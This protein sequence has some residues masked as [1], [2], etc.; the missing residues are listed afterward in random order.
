MD[1]SG[2]HSHD[3][4]GLVKRAPAGTAARRSPPQL[5]IFPPAFA[6]DSSGNVYIADWGNHRIRRIDSSGTITT[7]AGNRGFGLQ[8]GRRPGGRRTIE[9]PSGGGGRTE[10]VTSTSLI[11]RT[12]AFAGWIRREPSQTVSGKRRAGLQW[13]QRP[14]G[15][16]TVELSLWRGAGWRRQ[17]L[18]RRFGEPPD[19]PDQFLRDHHHHRRNRGGFSAGDGGPAGVAQ[20]R[21]PRGIAAD[22]GRQTFTLAIPENHRIR[23]VD[24]SGV[25]TTIAGNRGAGLWRRQWLGCRRTATHSRKGGAGWRRQCLHHRLHGNHRIRRV[26]PFGI[27]TTIAG[28]GEQG[29]SGDNGLAV[30]AQFSYPQGVAVGR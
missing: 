9:P 3:R 7:I 20:L 29:K 11:R 10:T 30:A 12:T 4:R 16:C 27:I 18:H 5:K 22:G 15:G 19:S 2:G 1:A 17:P 28:T 21:Y 26:D 25:I 24:A 14:G 23:W 13:G 8:R 6:V